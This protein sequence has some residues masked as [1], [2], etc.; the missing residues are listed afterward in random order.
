[1]GICDVP[2]I[3]ELEGALI[4]YNL[5]SNFNGGNIGLYRD[6]GLASFTE[7]HERKIG[8]QSVKGHLRDLQ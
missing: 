4:L 3:C 8:R 1:M 6:D 5:N 2:E 7:E